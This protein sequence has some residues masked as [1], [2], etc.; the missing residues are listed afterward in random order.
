MTVTGGEPLLQSAFTGAIL[1]RR[2]EAGLHRPRHLRFPRRARERR[3]PRRY[4]PGADGHEALR[5][6]DLPSD[7]WELALSLK[8]ATRRDRL[9]VPM[10]VRY[11]LVAGWKDDPTSR[12]G[13]GG[14]RGGARHGRPGGRPA[15]PHAQWRGDEALGIPFP[16]RDTPSPTRESIK[17]VRERFRGRGL[18]AY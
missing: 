16:L 17:Q 5:R 8:F 14:L 6:P 11:L 10:W 4:Q 7:R 12:S 18:K 3:T 2:K 13:T 1:R 15:V 9:G